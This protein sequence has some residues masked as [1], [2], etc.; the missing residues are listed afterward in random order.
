MSQPKNE[1]QTI[2]T[3]LVLNESIILYV[4]KSLCNV[5]SIWQHE[6]NCQHTA[7]HVYRR[8]K[9]LTAMNWVYH[10]QKRGAI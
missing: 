8:L 6:Q 5:L 9:L 10:N 3:N 1:L 2:V 7:L 4:K